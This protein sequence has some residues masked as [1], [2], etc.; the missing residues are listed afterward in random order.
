MQICEAIV[1][2][3]DGTGIKTPIEKLRDFRRLIGSYP[4]VVGA[5]VDSKNA[6]E[7]LSVA[8]GAI[9][10]SFLKNGDTQ[11]PVDRGRVNELMSEVRRLR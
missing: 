9:V 8:D 10:G 3:G 1:T 11:K 5:G 6:Y 4:L 7:Q 2:T